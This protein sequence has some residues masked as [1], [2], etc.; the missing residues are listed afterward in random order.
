M[1]QSVEERRQTDLELPIELLAG[2]NGLT[3]RRSSGSQLRQLGK[4]SLPSCCSW[5]AHRASGQYVQPCSIVWPDAIEGHVDTK[6]LLE[7]IEGGCPTGLPFIPR[8]SLTVAA[9]QPSFL[10]GKRRTLTSRV[11]LPGVAQAADTGSDGSHSHNTIL[12]S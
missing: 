8:R 11:G 6:R 5:I 12:G 1:G 4:L 3:V 2:I 9:S 7:L 10:T